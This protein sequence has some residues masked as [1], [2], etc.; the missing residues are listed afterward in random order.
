MGSMGN[1]IRGAT[2]SDGTMRHS[3]NR[4]LFVTGFALFHAWFISISGYVL[5]LPFLSIDSFL[6]YLAFVGA[7][8]VSSGLCALFPKT[9]QKI[10]EPAKNSLTLLV[11]CLLFVA[12]LSK[13]TLAVIIFSLSAGLLSGLMH[14]LY[15]LCCIS[16]S[17]SELVRAMG[18]TT[19]FA[20]GAVAGFSCTA[21]LPQ[22]W[23]WQS[24]LVLAF[25]LGSLIVLF[26]YPEGETETGSQLTEHRLDLGKQIDYQRCF[27]LKLLAAILIFG[28]ISR[29]CDIFTMSRYTGS[30][31]SDLFL[32]GS[33]CV[34]A[35]FVLVREYRGKNLASSYRFALPFIGVGFLLLSLPSGDAQFF[36][37]VASVLVGMGVEVF[38]IIAWV[39]IVRIV[40]EAPTKA[41][42]YFGAYAASVFVAIVLGKALNSVAFSLQLTQQPYMT[43]LL[44]LACVVT[45]IL[46]TLIVFPERTI[47]AFD[48]GI[49]SERKSHTDTSVAGDNAFQSRCDAVAKQYKLSEREKEVLV[50]LAKGRT[51]KVVADKLTIS[52]GTAGTHI[53]NIYRKTMV[54]RQQELIDLVES[55]TTENQDS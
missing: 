19:L 27:L 3:S 40:Q 48:S 15:G 39:L 8:V 32:Y 43:T 6:P 16:F 17:R 52:K 28:I 47:A 1:T 36:S 11:P 2:L 18:L 30:V 29:A 7:G 51:L 14:C 23:I 55:H 22:A 37:L 45:L 50:L 33:H 20:A 54:H 9:M 5:S 4:L 35:L 49:I 10:I 41:I 31:S 38:N 34:G 13:L 25:L 53:S 21:L 46:V 42:R 44:V 24:V 26:K 12:L